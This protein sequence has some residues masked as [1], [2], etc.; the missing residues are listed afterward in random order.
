METYTNRESYLE[1]LLRRSVLP[2][3]FGTGSVPLSFFPREKTVTV[4]MRMNLTAILLDEPTTVFAG[5]FT[6]NAVV[7][8]PVRL[9]REILA[10]REDVPVRGILVNNRIANVC[11]PGGEDDAREVLAAFVSAVAEALPVP[12]EGG[13]AGGKGPT[14]GKEAG[15]SGRFF[16][17]STGIIGWG[18]PVKE[19]VSACRPLA[20]ELA[21]RRAAGVDDETGENP[22]SGMSAAGGYG[23]ALSAAEGIMT[24][25]AYPKVRTRKVGEGR[26]TGIAKGAGMIEP[27]MGTL[28]VFLTTDI[29]LDR[30]EADAA[31]RR[32][33]E[34][35]FNR[36]TVDSDQSTSDM[37][38]LLSS[39]KHEAGL[40]EFARALEEV[41]V[42]LARD[43]V[44]NGEGTKHVL[45]VSVHGAA[46]EKEAVAFGKAV[47]N[48]PLVKTAV[49]GN[50]PNVGRILMAVGDYAGNAGIDLDTDVL[51]IAIGGTPVFT[52]GAFG[53]T[54]E[55]EKSL[56]DYLTE[57]AFDTSGGFPP[58]QR[59]VE[60]TL[61][62]GRGSAEAV[63]WGSDLSY[64][65]VKE[66][67]D[68]RS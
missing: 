32:V 63:V 1:A 67:A 13:G 48:S 62:L 42:D 47:C 35:S 51:E 19:M 4:P 28:L 31:L 18:L 41:C 57:A 33:V 20:A 49:F 9:G 40:E 25:D 26:I 68:Y 54:D 5:L 37:A 50:D 2:E 60:M 17:A 14:A 29:V 61:S 36:I 12:K 24:T 55:I 59:N 27:N 15:A 65:Y 58:H 64:D 11:A 56:F 46:S 39:R 43:I 6:R 16:P 8:A 23:N 21:A 44:R 7:G 10:E 52:R 45:E 30:D 66:N 34:R 53:L 3:G 22:A 38:L